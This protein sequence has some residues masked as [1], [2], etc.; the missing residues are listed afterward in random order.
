MQS[1]DESFKIAV[2]RVSNRIAQAKIM[3]YVE[4]VDPLNPYLLDYVAGTVQRLDDIKRAQHAFFMANKDTSSGVV[5]VPEFEGEVGVLSTLLQ[6]FLSYPPPYSS[7]LDLKPEEPPLPDNWTEPPSPA[8]CVL[9][10]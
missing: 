5:S 3:R 10:Q 6:V 9:T 7:R 2:A 8:T 4:E 1:H